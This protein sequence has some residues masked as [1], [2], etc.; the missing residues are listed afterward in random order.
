MSP[1]DSKILGW[2]LPWACSEGKQPY[3][4]SLCVRSE[5]VMQPCVFVSLQWWR[6]VSVSI[7]CLGIPG[8]PS[9]CPPPC[10]SPTSQGLFH[11]ELHDDGLIPQEPLWGQISHSSVVRVFCLERVGGHRYPDQPFL[12]HLSTPCS[13]VHYPKSLG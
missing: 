4:Q 6:H 12:R 7:R 3:L 13:P 1:G 9:S 11:H 2:E 10:P 8:G 5:V